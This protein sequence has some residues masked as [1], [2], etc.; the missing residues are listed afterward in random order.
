M[1]ISSPRRLGLSLVVGSVV[2]VSAA[3]LLLK[4][5]MAAIGDL[6]NLIDLM[7]R[8]QFALLLPLLGGLLCYAVSVVI[9]QRA[10]AELPLSLAYP[11]LSL[12]Y[13]LVYVA[14]LLLPG[15][16]ETISPQRVGG[17][18]FILIG[19]ALLAPQRADSVT[20]AHGKYD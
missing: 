19:I 18:L 5:A 17:L 9:W 14:A 15:F 8:M 4:Q 13:P 7:A 3:Q 20:E 10:L 12:S 1:R 11:L 6:H 16:T 2:L